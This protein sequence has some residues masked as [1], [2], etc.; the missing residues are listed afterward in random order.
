MTEIKTA[1]A[2]VKA[3]ADDDGKG[4]FTAVVSVFDTVDSYRDVVRK[5]AFTATLTEWKDSGDS[6]PVI[7]THN[8]HDAFAHIGYVTEAKETDE[9]LEITGQL[10][11]DNPTG[12]QV[13][14]LLKGRRIREFSFGYIVREA[15]EAELEGKYVRELR[16]VE[17]LEVSPTMVGA[18]R[19]TR[20][21][22]VK[23]HQTPAL[24]EK[25]RAA[26]Q[27]AI[28]A[29][30]KAMSVLDGTA[31]PQA[32]ETPADEEQNEAV[33]NRGPAADEEPPGAKSASGDDVAAAIQALELTISIDEIEE[34]R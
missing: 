20:L 12:A 17:L 8:A 15:A 34:I 16:D 28:E 14:K 26:I 10:D 2:Q 6:I 21:L 7:W 25:D 30:V 32:G 9:G 5:G 31:T 1:A 29:L 13:Y 24:S 33:A 18:N 4:Q 22:G 27:G 11:L 23:S 3:T 19:G